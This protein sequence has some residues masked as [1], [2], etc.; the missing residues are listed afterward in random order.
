MTTRIISGLLANPIF[1]SRFLKDYVEPTTPQCL[2]ILSSLSFPSHAIRLQDSWKRSSPEGLE[3]GSAA[4]SVSG[5]ALSSASLALSSRCA[6]QISVPSL[7]AV[8]SKVQV[9]VSIND[10]AHYQNRNCYSAWKGVHSRNRLHF[11]YHRLHA[12]MLS[13]L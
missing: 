6:P 1:V 13:R 3:P 5:L 11:F 10:C 9:L 8:P 7:L 4:E 12:V 2:L